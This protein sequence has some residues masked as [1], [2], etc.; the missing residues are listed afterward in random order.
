MTSSVLLAAQSG[1]SINCV[2]SN[3]VYRYEQ[4]CVHYVECNGLELLTLPS[5]N[6]KMTES[7]ENGIGLIGAT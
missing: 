4:L 6:S 2:V 5:C 7:S 1:A 3:A